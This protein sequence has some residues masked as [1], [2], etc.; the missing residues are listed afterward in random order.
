MPESSLTI[1]VLGG[2]G[3][4][5]TI[6]LLQRIIRLTPALDDVDHIRT[7]VDNNPQV[8]SRINYLIK[9]QGENPAPV[10][11]SMAESLESMGADL[12]VMPC[13][14]AHLY[15]PEIESAVSIRFLNMVELTVERV[16]TQV[17]ASKVGLLAST[18]IHQTK[19]YE[20]IFADRGVATMVPD[21]ALQFQLMKLIMAIKAGD[22][23]ESNL[24]QTI[25]ENMLGE[26]AECVV[27]ACTELSALVDSL[28]VPVPVI[29]AS[30]C[31][32]EVAVQLALGGKAYE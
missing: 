23:S 1:G 9:R 15:A 19:L 27:I 29:D 26:Q 18:A 28:D 25:V 13:N 12:L 14:T 4:T 20:S 31:L 24:L 5:A 3:P 11:V 8:P 2:M 6:D 32:A 21:D 17:Q 30:Q 16:A 7:L 22:L 10:L